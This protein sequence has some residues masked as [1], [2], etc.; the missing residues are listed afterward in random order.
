[1]AQYDSQK[2]KSKFP[3]TKLFLITILN[4]VITTIFVLGI[5]QIAAYFTS[6]CSLPGAELA[7]VL[8]FPEYLLI[9]LFSSSLALILIGL[10]FKHLSVIHP[11]WLTFIDFIL[12]WI[13]FLL[14]AYLLHVPGPFTGWLAIIWMMIAGLPIFLI[15][16]ILIY[17]SSFKLWLILFI[18]F[19]LL[20]VFSDY[21]TGSL[22]Y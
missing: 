1:M 19:L 16:Y 2:S 12:S 11:Y 4:T 20:C 22:R 14:I 5:P 8:C 10:F 13:A 7:T 6:W 15:S 17:K 9:I 3:L 21:I 18:I